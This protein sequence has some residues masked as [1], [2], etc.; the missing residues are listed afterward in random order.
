MISNWVFCTERNFL[1]CMENNHWVTIG[2]QL[3]KESL[4]ELKNK[5]NDEVNCDGNPSTQW[6][7]PS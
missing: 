4:I 6:D 2:H 3:S 1:F 5:P 7:F